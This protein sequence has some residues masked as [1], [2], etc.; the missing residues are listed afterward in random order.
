MLIVEIEY[1]LNYTNAWHGTPELKCKLLK[2]NHHGSCIVYNKC[3][4][5]TDKNPLIYITI[6]LVITIPLKC[7]Y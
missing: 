4:M 2:V 3:I 5:T 7:T 6:L 1:C